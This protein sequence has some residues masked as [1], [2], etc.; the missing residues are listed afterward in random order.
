VGKQSWPV[1][2]VSRDAPH[3]EPEVESPRFDGVSHFG[4]GITTRLRDARSFLYPPTQRTQQLGG[5]IEPTR[6]NNT[7]ESQ[8]GTNLRGDIPDKPGLENIEEFIR[9]IEDE[10]AIPPREVGDD[11]ALRYGEIGLP[12]HSEPPMLFNVA[13]FD[14]AGDT[15]VLPNRDWF[16]DEPVSLTPGLVG[17]STPFSQTSFGRPPSLSLLE[18]YSMN[19]HEEYLRAAWQNGNMF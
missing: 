3:I 15:T 14:G 4:Q 1:P 9:R 17:R 7:Y 10:T 8:P 5:H 19:E 12:I 13:N 16:A 2:K 6:P 18:S 11:P